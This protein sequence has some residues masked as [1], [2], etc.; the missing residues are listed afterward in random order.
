MLQDLRFA[1]RLLLRNRWL[2]A[3]AVT[4]LALGIGAN[5]VVFTL[6]NAVL[7][8]GLPYPDGDRIVSLGT[9]DARGRDRAVSYA[10]FVDWR[11]S[12]RSMRSLGASGGAPMTLAEADHAAERFQGAFISA[13]GLAM[14]GE[15]PVVGRLFTAAD[16]RPGAP[17]VV[18]LG[19]T[20]WTTRYGRDPAILGRVV[21]VNGI[22]STVIGVMPEQFRFP[23]NNDVWQPLSAMPN[24]TTL[25]RDRRTLQV[26]GK[27]GPGVTLSQATEEL[28]SIAARLERDFADTNTGVRPTV[29]TWAQRQN[30]GPIRLMFLSL[31]G[32]VGFVLLIACAN[33]ANL[34][35]SR[36][37]ER[38][39]EMAVRVSIGA[40]RWQLMRQLLTE[41]VLL[42]MAG[43]LLG[44]ALA[45]IGVRVFDAVTAEP[46]LGRPYWIRFTMDPT[47]LAF[48]AA[49]C[50][51]T[52]LLFG[53]APALH[54]LRG[55]V[56]ELLKE[57]GRSGSSGIQA[58]RWTSA[59]LIVELALTLVLLAGAG[60]MMRSF[61]VLYQLDLGIATSDMT[62]VRLDLP[63]QTYP[64]SE[65]RVA[66]LTRL[67]ERLAATSAFTSA[68]IANA[69]PMGGGALRQIDLEERPSDPGALPPTATLILVGARYFQT[70][71]VTPRGRLFTD[72]DGLPGRDVVIVNE[73]LASLYFPNADPIGRRLRLTDE[74]TRGS[75]SG[76]LTIIGV[77]PTIRQRGSNEREPD[78]VVYRPYRADPMNVVTLIVRA[79]G[80]PSQVSSILP[81]ELLALD[82]DMPLVNVR[83]LD[84]QLSV[85][86]WPYRV[87]GTMF[88]VFAVIALVLSGVGL[89]AVTTRSVVERTR[90]IGVRLVLGAGPSQIQWMIV[91]QAALMIGFGLTLGMLGAFGVGRLLTTLLVQ[92]SPTDAVTL[93]SIA[94]LL[95]VIAGL[96]CTLPARRACRLDPA[97]ALRKE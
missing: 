85:A 6:V 47:V 31:M 12:A 35:L 21:R 2:T 70:L 80:G 51:G 62:V 48:F 83:S 20:V 93:G 92:T 67:E 61:L 90:E 32:A 89:Y 43:G 73:R 63:E 95:T 42:S 55:N 3:A 4:A 71:G 36:A 49:I 39:P 94:M 22:P 57:S 96:A 72:D 86:R 27:L 37:A 78:A 40:T 17:A 82:P 29:M 69:F 34:M 53:L 14:V 52:G 24:V 75:T 88:T 56:G 54:V 46:A 11:E 87:F 45:F 19:Y 23:N 44:L 77:S 26:F 38:A 25:P 60:F 74:T 5:A 18:V 81:R 1:L 64:T 76:W 10:D 41:S 9:R 79:P 16:D 28:T 58:R 7:I 15:A 50:V 33:V 13:D 30:G 59:L 97:V 91:R 84:D 8:R 68:A 66:F 65:S